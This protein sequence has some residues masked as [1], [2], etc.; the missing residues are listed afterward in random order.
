MK[1]EVSELELSRLIEEYPEK[2]HKAVIEEKGRLPHRV[3]YYTG[4]RYKV[5][6]ENIVG[7][8]KLYREIPSKGFDAP[9]PNRYYK[10]LHI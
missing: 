2:L 6:D 4:D 3:V 9:K 5:A 10:L 8:I 1:Q 7:M